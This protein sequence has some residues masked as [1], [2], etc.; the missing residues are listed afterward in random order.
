MALE[1]F[2]TY[3]AVPLIIKGEVKGVL[4]ILNRS[5]LEPD[6]EWLDFLNTLATQTAIAIDNAQLYEELQSANMEMR[7]AYETTLEGWSR[8]LEMRDMET[9][10]HSQ[11]VTRMTML[12]AREMNLP[13]EA[14]V[15]IRRGALLHD[16]GKMAIPDQILRKPGPLNDEEWALMRQ[17][18]V[19]AYEML[20][21]IPYLHPA[22]EIPYSHHERW[23]GSGYPQGLK[24]EAIPLPAR[25]FAVVDVYDALISERPY[26]LAWT[27]EEALDYIRG[28]ARLQFDPE[29]VEIF[30]RLQS[31]TERI[32]ENLG[33]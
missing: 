8:A 25:I 22:L 23:D 5:I 14:L 24:G 18:P 28:Q 9:K 6:Q 26:R 13:E 31:V 3:F 2:R 29:V 21:S 16:I 17:H 19:L 7:L 1:N 15:H 10:G 27:N 33:E 32:T 30:L 12:L 20:Q 11:R 4:E